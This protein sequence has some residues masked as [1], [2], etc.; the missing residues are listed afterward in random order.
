MLFRSI[1][2]SVVKPYD[3]SRASTL[4]KIMRGTALS[5]VVHVLLVFAYYV[6]EQDNRYSREFLL[7][8]YGSFLS[9]VFLF[10]MLSQLTIRRL[11]MRGFNYRNLIVVKHR[12]GDDQLGKYVTA[13]PEYGYHVKHIIEA[14]PTDLENRMAE[15]RKC[16]IESGID[17]I[18]YPISLVNYDSLAGLKIG[19]AHV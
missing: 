16:C 7:L 1:A 13:H 12:E 4:F 15:I 17:E 10:R 2:V 14:D 8:F 18:F 3:I 5:L 9:F 19:R 11:R 6:F